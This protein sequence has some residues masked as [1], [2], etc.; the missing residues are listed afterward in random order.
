[1]AVAATAVVVACG[2]PT[3]SPP[4]SPP[5]TATGTYASAFD[6]CRDIDARVVRD[7]GFNPATRE[8]EPATG[9]YTRACEFTSADMSLVVSTSWTSFEEFRDRYA[10]FREGLDIGTR[11]AVIVR[12]P[13]ADQPC[14]LAMKTSDGIVTLQTILNVTAKQWGMDRCARIADIARVI[15]PSI[16][17]G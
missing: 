12:K 2:S 5:V 10:G 9:E 7:A 6:P 14:E 17:T 3:V 11:P 8:S 4:T 13:Q 1:M 15:E 16:G